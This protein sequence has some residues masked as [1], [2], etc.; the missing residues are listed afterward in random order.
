MNGEAW[1]ELA[2]IFDILFEREN[3][4]TRENLGLRFAKIEAFYPLPLLRQ[5]QD[6]GGE[7]RRKR[8]AASNYFFFAV[9]SLFFICEPSVGAAAGAALS[10]FGFLT[11]LLLRI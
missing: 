10:F 11:S 9:L 6:D 2:G 5:A 8:I 7:D 3:P 1:N 4:S